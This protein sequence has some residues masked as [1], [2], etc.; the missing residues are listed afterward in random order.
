MELNLNNRGPAAQLIEYLSFECGGGILIYQYELRAFVAFWLEDRMLIIPRTRVELI[1]SLQEEGF[2]I[3]WFG[4]PAPIVLSLSLFE[5]KLNVPIRRNWNKTFTESSRSRLFFLHLVEKRDTG[6]DFTSHAE[7]DISVFDR[8]NESIL[9]DLLSF[10]LTISFTI[11]LKRN[12]SESPRT[13]DS[14]RVFRAIEKTIV[15]TNFLKVRELTKFLNTGKPN[16]LREP[17]FVLE[18]ESR[19]FLHLTL[20]SYAMFERLKEFL[21][22]TLGKE[23]RI[24]ILRV[25]K[26]TYPNLTSH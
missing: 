23:V 17:D 9:D 14:S 5:R 24:V 10:D 20:D 7:R 2:R 1:Y 6:L 12:L 22:E 26:S 15:L 21:E 19:L 18:M 11:H 3:I 4:G 25:V 8:L 13:F 16:W